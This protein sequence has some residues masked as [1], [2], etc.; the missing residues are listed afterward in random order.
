MHAVYGPP[1]KHWHTVPAN[2]G[3]ARDGR[4]LNAQGLRTTY[5]DDLPE[6]NFTNTIIFVG[7]SF[8][9][10]ENIPRRL[11][12]PALVSRASPATRVVNLGASGMA[13]DYYR[14]AISH[15]AAKYDDI[16]HVFIMFY[17]N[18]VD[19]GPTNRISRQIRSFLR[20]NTHAYYFLAAARNHVKY[21][22]L[23]WITRQGL[24][25][26]EKPARETP[27]FNAPGLFTYIDTDADQ[28]AAF[29]W[30][31]SELV[32]MVGALPSR[33][34]TIVTVIPSPVLISPR[35]RKY[36][37]STG[38]TAPSL[39]GHP[40]PAYETAR[41]ICA[42][43]PRCHFLDIFDA[44]I[45]RDDLYFDRDIHWNEAGHAFMANTILASNILGNRE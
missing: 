35:F 42:K 3:G 6:R 12:F 45:G 13:P 1:L 23:P 34:K 10:G 4:G 19:T 28:R 17:D 27:V 29:A 30:E 16:T 43:N 33:P 26:G 31:V 40:S 25:L 18:D 9:F 14:A 37:L 22:V 39:P 41:E 2:E 5:S 11:D 44:L 38:A 20:F 8:T 24:D 32:G 15:Y 7:D 21:T 36:A